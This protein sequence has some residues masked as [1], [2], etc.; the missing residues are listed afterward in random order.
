MVAAGCATGRAVRSAQ[1]AADRGDWDAAVAF[2]REALSRDPSRV[3]VKVALERAMRTASGEHLKRA[4][5]LEGQDQLPGA[6]A[7][8]RLAASLDPGN[9]FAATKA[10]ELERRLRDQTEASRPP[11]RIEQLRQQAAQAQGLPRLD[12]RT[13]ITFI[14]HTGS[15]RDLL[16]TI[17]DMTGIGVTYEQS[18]QSQV[19]RPFPFEIRNVSAEEALAQI[20][21][22]NRLTY[23]VIGPN[24]I[25]VYA[26]TPQLRQI[27]EDQYVQSFMLS[28]ADASETSGIL[29]Q[30][31]SQGATGSRPQIQV[32][33]NGNMLIIKGTLPVLTAID[34]IIRTVDKPRAEVMI[35][36]E[37]LEVDRNFLKQI[38]LD[39]NQW[40][41]GF[42]YSPE[43]APTVGGTGFPQTPPPINL[44]TPRQGVG[45]SDFYVTVPT[46]LVRILESDSRTRVLARPSVRGRDGM[47]VQLRLG[48]LVPIPTTV[49]QSSAGGG[50]A[51]IPTT[52]VNYQ[53]VG[54]NLLFT[55]RVTYQDEVI[56]ENLTLEKSGLGPNLDIGGQTFPTIVSRNAMTT[57]R[58]R[59][60]ESNL[61]A[62]LIREEDRREARALPGLSRIPGLRWLFGNTT[63]TIDQSDVV[64]I[65]T[66]RIVRSAEL[67][68]D[69]LKPMFVGV[70]QNFGSGAVPQLISPEALGPPAVVPP[71][72]PTPPGQ[73]GAPPA[74]QPGTP[75][76][77][78]GTPPRATGV[79]PITPVNPAAEPTGTPSQGKVIVSP[80][81]AP[82]T[83]GAP[84]TVPISIEGV[85]QAVGV[86]S[87]TLTY[88]PTVLRAVNV[89]Q[90]THLQQGGVTTTFAPK[91]DAATGRVDIAIARPFD[92]PGATGNG[93]LGAVAF[94]AVRSGTSPITI[95]GV[96]TTTTGQSIP[97]QMVSGSVTVK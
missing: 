1:S 90:G 75:P 14:R 50:V 33:K 73:P 91:I 93:L 88:D 8:Y 86:L 38:G 52:S 44:S 18:T 9:T 25:F 17:S 78:T 29:N 32:N 57:I 82:L 92:R 13:P 66:P 30:L 71:G 69:D 70:G 95:Q 42:T 39:L 35:D 11:P 61:L 24:T 40:A 5:D 56:L 23:K 80:P 4:R 36:A 26:D 59:D 20:M 10:A 49:F 67:T 97:V 76:T 85:T 62:G 28:H 68:A 83:A 94:E 60:G 51:N 12:P 48:D 77:T 47:A 81:S 21:S 34:K 27:Y 37:I 65:I 16:R 84:Y 15:I 3:D 63:T 7:E 72:T 46:A 43:A 2:Y 6:I 79:V 45:T 22:A 41:L 19:D 31:L 58:L 53:S 89:V 74:G 54:V 96:L 55:P 64:M 87:L